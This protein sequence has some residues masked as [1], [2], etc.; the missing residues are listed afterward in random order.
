TR[1][2]STT[3]PLTV[4]LSTS[5]A[6]ELTVP[7]TV[8]IPAGKSAAPFS[9]TVHQDGVPDHDQLVTVTAAASGYQSGTARVTVL[10]SDPPQLTVQLAV[11]SVIEGGQVAGTVSRNGPLDSEVTVHL[12]PAGHQ[13]FILPDQVT[14]PTGAASA[15]FILVARDDTQLQPQG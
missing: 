4:A 13:R 7:A 3:A 10:N 9:L 11:G 8:T 1:N 6:A 14:I 12:S 15:D 5:S 2:G